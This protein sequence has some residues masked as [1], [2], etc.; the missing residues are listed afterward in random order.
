MLLLLSLL[1]HVTGLPQ[2]N[3][4]SIMRADSLGELMSVKLLNNSQ[5]S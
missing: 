1:L 4:L 2:P 5:Q 3:W